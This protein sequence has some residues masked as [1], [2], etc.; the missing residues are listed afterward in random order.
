MQVFKNNVCTLKGWF[1]H[2]SGEVLFTV[3]RT[4]NSRGERGCGHIQYHRTK[5]EKFSFRLWHD[6]HNWP[7]TAERAHVRSYPEFK[8]ITSTS[9]NVNVALYHR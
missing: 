8:V 4:W 1:I 6:Q 7:N 2:V 3:H 5:T 9:M